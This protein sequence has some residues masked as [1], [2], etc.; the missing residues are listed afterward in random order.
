MVAKKNKKVVVQII[1]DTKSSYLMGLIRTK[2]D[3]HLQRDRTR[4]AE[5]SYSISSRFN[6]TENFKKGG[7]I[8]FSFCG[9]AKWVEDMCTYTLKSKAAL[10]PM[11][12]A[13]KISVEDI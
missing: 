8:E 3:S 12:P 2:I 13:I 11:R 6:D 7:V 4:T 10:L 5:D 9:R 1:K